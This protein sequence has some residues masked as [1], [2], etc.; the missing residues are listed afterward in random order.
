MEIKKCTKESFSVIGK[1][2]STNDGEGFVQKL[3]QDANSHFDEIQALVKKDE[4]GNPLG[5][6]GAMSDFSGAFQPWEENFSKGLYLAGAEV[7]DDAAAPEGWT[8]WTIPG[9]EYLYIKGESPEEFSSVIKYLEENEINLVGAVNDF[10]CPEE[11]GQPYM[12]FP[13]KRL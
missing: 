9:Y 2:G 3:W 10:M 11:N 7:L 4:T 1:L 5:F 8:K 13:I 6:W 12:F